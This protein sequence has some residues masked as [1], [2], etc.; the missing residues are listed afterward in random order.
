MS[1]GVS[2]NQMNPTFTPY[3]SFYFSDNDDDD[4]KM[5]TT[6]LA[7]LSSFSPVISVIIFTT[8]AFV[9]TYAFPKRITRVDQ[10]HKYPVPYIPF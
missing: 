9:Q 10:I 8:L 3:Y 2:S 1:A 7:M 5:I 4:N 6:M